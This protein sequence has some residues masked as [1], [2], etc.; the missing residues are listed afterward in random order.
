MDCSKIRALSWTVRVRRSKLLF[1]FIFD[2]HI[3]HKMD[4]NSSTIIVP[5]TRIVLT[6][7]I[8]LRCAY[9]FQERTE[10]YEWGE[11]EPIS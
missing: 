10:C 4:I 1:I 2:V 9:I 8:Y 11:Q 6:T 5:I 7:I 3:G